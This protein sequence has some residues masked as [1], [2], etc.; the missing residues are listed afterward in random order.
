[1]IQDE[2]PVKKNTQKRVWDKTKKNFVWQ[3]DQEDKFS[4]EEKGKKAY[5]KWKKKFNLAIPKAGEME[6]EDQIQRAKQNWTTRRK[7]RHGW[8]ENQP[9]G[10]KR[11]RD[12]KNNKTKAIEKKFKKRLISKSQKS[13]AAKAGGKPGKGGMKK[14][15]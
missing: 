15:R 7:A 2:N 9:K 13:K 6:D 1:M 14:R 5:Q 4:K 12:L 3:R 11:G 10:Q 8:K